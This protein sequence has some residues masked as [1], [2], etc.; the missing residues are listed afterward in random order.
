MKKITNDQKLEL[1]LALLHADTESEVEKLLRKYDLWFHDE[2]WR[3]LGDSPAN[4]SIAG[5]QQAKPVPSLIEKLV[6]SID[7]VLISKCIENGIEP[8][9]D[10]APENMHDAVEKFFS[11][12]N[13][14]LESVS[15]TERTKLAQYIHLICTGAKNH[16]PCYTIVDRGEGQTPGKIHSTILSLPGTKNP[17]KKGIPFVQGIFNMGG[18]GVTRFCGSQSLQL[19]VTR[20]NPKLLPAS[21]NQ[22]DTLWS[23]TVIRR[24]SPT[25]GRVSSTLVYLA[26]LHVSGKEGNDTL[27]FSAPS[28]PALPDSYNPKVTKDFE[29]AFTKPIEFGTCIKLYEYKIGPG[30]RT[31]IQFDLNYE[32][33]R[34]F[35]QMAL[36]VRLVE[37]RLEKPTGGRFSGHSFDTNLSGMTVRLQEA[38]NNLIQE[39]FFGAITVPSIGELDVTIHVLQNFHS[40]RKDGKMVD[41]RNNYHGGAEIQVIVN[42]QTHGA[43]PRSLFSRKNVGL[44]HIESKLFVILD[45][46][47]IEPHAKENLFMASRDRLADGPEKASLEEALIEHLKD[48]TRLSQLNEEEKQKSL[49]KAM[50]DTSALEEVF[51]GLVRH[52]PVLSKWFPQFG[53]VIKPS[54]FKWKK[55]PGEYK[56]NKTPTFFRIKDDAEKF[57]IKFPINR[58]GKIIFEHDADNDY[59]RR[60]VK[61]AKLKITIYD[62]KKKQYIP[63]QDLIK[64]V[65]TIYGITNVRLQPLINSKQ[66]DS[67][68]AKIELIDKKFAPETIFK[69]QIRILK[70][71]PKGPVNNCPC[72]CHDRGEKSCSQCKD[73][74]K[75]K[76]SSLPYSRTKEKTTGT[77]EGGMSLPKTVP[78]FEN[79]ENWT[80]KGFTKSTGLKV[81]YDER[82]F[83][84]YVNMDNE[85]LIQGLAGEKEPDFLTTLYQSAMS[86]VAFGMYHKMDSKQSKEIA[87]T[88]DV[89]QEKSINDRVSDACDGVAMV[90]LPIITKLGP[91]ARRITS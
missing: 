83:I 44:D 60:V 39:K 34:H 76:S 10:A 8:K 4:W 77:G 33:N 41:N 42:G 14:I 18:T 87:E 50:K 61:P 22:K 35:F 59:F 54:G 43:L 28:I 51:T 82:D 47:K 29:H 24:H 62:K 57:N 38:K 65:S 73:N 85:Y 58:S 16:E 89:S 67:I 11:I 84:V 23:F 56:G 46:T 78:V 70:K 19:I 3:L 53:P 26:P 88:S 74:H 21:P 17:N 32:L 12:P 79:D 75:L 80:T 2:N 36:P 15:S 7:T 6:N 13:G 25:K 37:R 81:S 5:N 9:S 30:L 1:C 64:S 27:T 40:Q 20:R 48:N 86:M 72:E 68:K 71:L 69:G 31:N 45:A 91:Q 49:E 52:D 90:L 63:K 66:G 55:S